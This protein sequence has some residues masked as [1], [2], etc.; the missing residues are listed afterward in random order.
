MGEQKFAQINPWLPGVQQYFL[1]KHP[2]QGNFDRPIWAEG[3]GACRF[4]SKPRQQPWPKPAREQITRVQA[5]TTQI[6]LARMALLSSLFP[7]TNRQNLWRFLRH[8]T[9]IGAINGLHRV[10]L[11]CKVKA[12]YWGHDEPCA[13]FLPYSC[14]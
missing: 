7:F 4:T 2:A 8:I 6:N 12:F 3:V 11:R 5:P 9:E 14:F 1:H 13:S 10:H